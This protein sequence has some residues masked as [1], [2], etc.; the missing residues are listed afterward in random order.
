MNIINKGIRKC[1]DW[2]IVQLIR[3]KNP[4]INRRVVFQEPNRII[5]GN[6]CKVGKDSHILCWKEYKY[7]EKRQLLNSKLVI[8]DNFSATRKFTIQCC[9]LIIIGKDV[10]IASDV[11]ICDYNHGIENPERNYLDN[12]LMLGEVV[13]SDG[14][15]IGQGAYILP[16]VHIGKNSIVGA[17]SVV[18]KDIPDYCIAVGNPARVIKKYDFFSE[19]WVKV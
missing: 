2:F 9:N 6:N 3:K 19:E 5:W 15:W 4:G 12:K 7:S 8:G 17:G 13:I 18:T 10:L 1:R 16:G 14:V 11:F